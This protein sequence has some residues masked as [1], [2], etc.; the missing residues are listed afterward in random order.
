MDRRTFLGSA[1]AAAVMTQFSWAASQHRLEKIGLELYTVRDLL[2]KDFEGTLAK[3][4]K[5]GYKEVEL[6]GYLN[7]LP[8]L[9]PPIKR[10]REIVDANGLSAPAAHVAYKMLSPENWPK[11]IEASKILGHEYIVNPSIDRELTKTSDG[12]KRAAETFNRAGEESQKS[13]IKH[14]FVEH[15][16][17]MMPLESIQKSYAYLEKLRF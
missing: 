4:A 1:T 8:N 10:A 16:Q 12:W 17:P 7:D 9:D 5:I 15:D 2:K 6:A 14:Y 11:V 3:V 13:G